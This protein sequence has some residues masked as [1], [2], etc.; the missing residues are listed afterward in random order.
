LIS[1]RAAAATVAAAAVAAALLVVLASGGASPYGFMTLRGVTR[2][3]LIVG[4]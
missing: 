4:E 3:L 1:G 2:R